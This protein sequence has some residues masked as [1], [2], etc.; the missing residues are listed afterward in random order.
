MALNAAFSLSTVSATLPG[1]GSDCEMTTDLKVSGNIAKD[2]RGVLVMQGKLYNTSSYM[3]Y[4]DVLVKADLYDDKG[5]VI[6]SQTFTVKKDVEKGETE[7]FTEP[8]KPV[9]RVSNVIYNVVCADHSFAGIS[10]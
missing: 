5:N 7:N 6:D 8:L 9:A 4:K 3:E 2:E 10:Y 1:R